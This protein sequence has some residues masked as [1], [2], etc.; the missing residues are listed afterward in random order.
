MLKKLFIYF[1]LLLQ[2]YCFCVEE[3]VNNQNKEEENKTYLASFFDSIFDIGAKSVNT[4]EGYFKKGLAK[5]ILTSKEV[6][7]YVGYLLSDVKNKVGSKIDA[8]VDWANN[9]DKNNNNI[10]K[11]DKL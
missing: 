8:T 10:D 3:N 4:F 9:I 6:V 5:A 1:V 2:S 7:I 11:N